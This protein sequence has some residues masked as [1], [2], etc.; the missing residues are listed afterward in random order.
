MLSIKSLLELSEVIEKMTHSDIDRIVAVFGFHPRAASEQVSRVTKSTDIFIELKITNSVGPFGSDLKMELLQYVVDRFFKSSGMDWEGGDV[1]YAGKDITQR[2]ENAFSISNRELSN[3]LKRDGYVIEGK[4]IKKLLPEEIEEAKIESELEKL[5]LEFEFTQ[6]KGHLGQAIENH[7]SSNW[8]GANSQFR[9]FFESLLIEISNKILPGNS[10]KSAPGAIKL[11]SESASPPFILSELNEFD[12]SD[13]KASYLE[14][15]WARLNP[16]G[17]HPGL[18][19]EEDCT[20]RY[21]TTIVI[22]R[23]LLARLKEYT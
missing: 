23:L 22:A 16:E 17:S 20:F 12:K 6:S 21:H 14:G 11:L 18:S 3:A 15:F 8:A 1:A 2:F 4:T 7:S 13:K 9:T 5:L 19:S 10:P